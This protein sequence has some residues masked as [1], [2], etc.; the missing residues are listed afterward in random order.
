MTG[1]TG[2]TGAGSAAEGSGTLES[3]RKIAYTITPRIR[4]TTVS[5]P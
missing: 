2:V 4:Y 3:R 5:A 1:V